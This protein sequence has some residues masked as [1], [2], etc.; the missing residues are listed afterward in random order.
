V[1][2]QEQEWID[3]YRAALAQSES[4]QKSPVK[5]MVRRVAYLV[6]MIIGKSQKILKKVQPLHGSRPPLP[7]PA[8]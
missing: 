2:D 6:G 5:A 8:Q 7:P 1:P 3:K 4:P